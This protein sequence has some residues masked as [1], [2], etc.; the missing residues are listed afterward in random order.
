MGFIAAIDSAFSQTF[1]WRGRASRSEFWRV[2]LLYVLSYIASLVVTSMTQFPV[3]FFVVV[4]LF[5]PMLGLAVRRLHDT[6]RSGYW[7]FLNWIPGGAIVL[8]VFYCLRSNAGDNKYGP[9]PARLTGNSSVVRGMT[10]R[11][12]TRLIGPPHEQ[13]ETTPNKEKNTRISIVRRLRL[14]RDYWH[15]IG[16]PDEAREMMITFEMG[17]VVDITA[18]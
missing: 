16:L 4:G 12:V 11:Q 17:R 13:V 10:K 14:E 6:G 2:F 7:Y 8:L 1:D 3:V 9:P 18:G 15:Y 5:V